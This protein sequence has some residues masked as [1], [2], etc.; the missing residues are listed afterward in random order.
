MQ[1]ND[2]FYLIYQEAS[3]DDCLLTI[4]PYQ[5]TDELTM[6][7]RQLEKLAIDDY[8]IIKGKKMK[9]TM[10]VMIDLEEEIDQKSKQTPEKEE[11]P[12]FLEE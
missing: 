12:G 7:L 1:K 10:R 5:T 3:E 11:N 8:T 6:A 9:A 2:Q 4:Q